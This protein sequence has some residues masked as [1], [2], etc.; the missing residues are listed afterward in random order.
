MGPFL[1]MM[2]STLMSL[3]AAGVLSGCAQLASLAGIGQP[4]III[5]PSRTDAL[6]VSIPALGLRGFAERSARN[7]DVVSWSM[8]DT[9]TIAVNQG[10]IVSTR[11]LGDDL[12][13]ADAKQSISVANGAA[14]GWAPRING[15]MNGAYQSYF[16]T[17]QCRRADARPSQITVGDRRQT[18]T[19][20]TET[21]V[22]ETYK[23]EN[24]YWRN[25]NGLVLKAHQW[26][27]PAVGYLET[28]R[29][30]R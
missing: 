23:I 14:R 16:I 12:M 28:T 29:L 9:V 22:N 26:V 19:Q 13:G 3:A 24:T 6:H 27:S 4:D 25:G 21:C 2:R 11:G 8:D 20:I 17:F 10:V 7:G 5:D 1:E 18:V 15:Y 30:L